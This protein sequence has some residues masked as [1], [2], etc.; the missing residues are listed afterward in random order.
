MLLRLVALTKDYPGLR[1]LD[2]VDFDLRAGECH[3]LFGENGSGKSTLISMVAG[4]Q[5]PTSGKIIH[6]GKEVCLHS[7]Q[8]A[9]RMGISTVFQE[10]S[11]VPQL[12][13]ADN[14]FLGAEISRSGMLRKSEQYEEAR[15]LISRFDFALDVGAPVGSLSR[16]E[17]QMVEIAKAF[18]EPPS[19]LI[20]DEPTA[21]L[22]NQ[23][24]D[25]LFELI[26][27]LK[28]KGVGI[29]YITHR[30]NELKRV[31]DRITVLRDGRY[32]AT[33]NAQIVSESDL[34]HMM[35]GRTISE[36]FPSVHFTPGDVALAIDYLTTDGSVRNV[37]LQVRS[38]EIVGLAGLV[39]SGKSE[40][41]RACY[42][43]ENITA[44]TVHLNG[45]DVTGSSS[46]KMLDKGMF[47]LPPDRRKEGLVMMRSCRENI[48]LP[49][50]RGDEFVRFGVLRHGAEKIRIGDLAKKFQLAPMNI[51]QEA[52][53]FSGGNQQKIM[54]ARSLVLRAGVF[55][56]DEPTVGVDVGTRTEIYHF[57]KELCEGGA[58]VLLISSDLPE[59][60]NL[61]HRVFVF[62]NGEMRVQL[63]GDEITEENVLAHFFERAVA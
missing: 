60:I 50:L 1:A 18:R 22:T 57:I 37:S 58:A 41:A 62:Y 16:A 29:I 9:R 32:V 12:S 24:V 30:M 2:N 17:Q 7:V 47:Y 40:I 59:V 45:E 44:G 35:T 14:I 46:G 6:Q 56:F 13:V 49:A 21:S 34:I 15:A 4:V 38:G 28:L 43:L 48:A 33:V 26:V 8:E 3:V 19:V 55:I 10:F 5:S 23:E 54:L 42:G 36:V 52:E 27:N 61:S 53:F 25:K 39:G 20:L 51:E 63:L 11:L 31:G